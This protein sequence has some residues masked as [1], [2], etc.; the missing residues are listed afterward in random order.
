MH[1]KYNHQT[2]N[3]Y[4][5]PEFGR[6]KTSLSGHKN[7]NRADQLY[8]QINNF[9][10]YNKISQPQNHQNNHRNNNQ[11]HQKYSQNTHL[12][13]NSDYATNSDGSGAQ[14]GVLAGKISKK[15]TENA[16]RKSRS[17]DDFLDLDD[18]TDGQT[19]FVSTDFGGNSERNSG[20]NS[21]SENSSYEYNRRRLKGGSHQLADTKAQLDRVRASLA[22]HRESF[23]N[24]R[25]QYSSQPDISSSFRSSNGN[26]R[27]KGI[28]AKLSQLE[29]PPSN[30]DFSRYESASSVNSNAVYNLASSKRRFYSQDFDEVG[31]GQKEVEKEYHRQTIAGT[32]TGGTYCPDDRDLRL[33]STL[34]SG[35]ISKSEKSRST[36]NDAMLLGR[37]LN[38]MD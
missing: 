28:K 21:G 36:K 25:N 6:A 5:K 15:R 8:N 18:E 31:I 19:T 2:S 37:A 22:Q 12:S 33:Y 35:V 9:Q 29:N 17:R 38:F 23:K 3:P 16:F 32:S 14:T 10:V 1:K 30:D 20:K 34:T 24:S 26:L 13:S 11:N 7:L 4:I 27:Q